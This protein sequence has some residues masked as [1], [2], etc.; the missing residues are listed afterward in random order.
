M[1]LAWVERLDVRDLRNIREASVELHPGLNVFHG[2]N[3]QG[4]TSL[5]EAVGVVARGRSFRTEDA[6]SMI[7]RGAAGLLA[8]ARGGEGRASTLEVE[9]RPGQRVFRVDGRDVTCEFHTEFVTITWRSAL[10]DKESFPSGIGL[11]AAFGGQSSSWPRV[12]T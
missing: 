1:A 2:R 5:L 8:Q 10:T 11:D 7:R 4:K 3:A 12:S 9:L 6:P